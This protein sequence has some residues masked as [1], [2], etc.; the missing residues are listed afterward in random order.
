MTTSNGV[1]KLPIGIQ[2]MKFWLEQRI[3]ELFNAI[4]RYVEAGLSENQNVRKWREEIIT[5]ITLYNSIQE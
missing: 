3:T 2:P 1:P 4:E 5:L